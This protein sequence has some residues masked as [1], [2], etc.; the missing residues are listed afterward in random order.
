M[1]RNLAEDHV[2]Q[3]Y[4]SLRRHFPDFCGCNV[5]REDVLV[6][7]LNRVPPRYVATLEG[8][9]VTE[10]NLEKEQSRAPIDVAMMEGFRK[11]SLAPRC[12]A[13]GAHRRA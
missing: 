3:A 5:C 13:R 6:F 11:V 9:V 4:E 12:D 8:S 1:I 10:V 7:T 2:L